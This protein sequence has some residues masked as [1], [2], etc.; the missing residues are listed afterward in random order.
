MTYAAPSASAL[1]VQRLELAGRAYEL[2][3]AGP[4]QALQVQAPLAAALPV[5]RYHEQMA[6][7]AACLGQRGQGLSLDAMAL[8][9]ILLDRAGVAAENQPDLMPLALWWAGG[10]SG[11]ASALQGSDLPLLGGT[12][13][14]RPWSEG[15]RFAALSRCQADQG[16]GPQFQAIAYLDAMVRASVQWL[17]A[18]GSAVS[19]LDDLDAAST[20]ALLDAVVGLNVLRPEDEVLLAA[21]AA[22]AL[23]AQSAARTLNLCRL[24]GWTP[25]QVWAAPAVEIAR[26]EALIQR[27][28]PAV[29]KPAPAARRRPSLADAPDAVVI[30][31]D[32]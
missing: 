29:A 11:L 26:L 19:R 32:D 6:A 14:L 23:A 13:R 18:A 22:S 27:S 9:M 1:P 10:A 15:E 5:W 2:I 25:S 16:Q 8:A 12:A 3:Y 17:P 30:R 28:Q 4:D 24:L 20:Q 31:I 7:L 21:D